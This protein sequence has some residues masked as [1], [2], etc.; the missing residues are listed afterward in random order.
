MKRLA[1]ILLALLAFPLH[2]QESQKFGEKIDVNVV[3]LDAIV[4]DH[5]G[6]QILGLGPDDFDVRENGTPQKIDSV[7]YFTN[8]TLLTSPEEKAAFKVERVREDRYFVFFFDKPQDAA[9]FDDVMRARTAAKKFAGQLRP[10]DH[11][12]VAGHDVRLK[13]YGDFSNDPKQLAR[14]IDDAGSFGVGLSS[15]AGPILSTVDKQRMMSG[16]GT[17]YEALEVLGD[18][19]RGVKGRKNLILFSPGILEPGQ[20]VRGGV[21]VAQSR[22]Y[23]PMIDALN[24]AN[25]SVYAM[26]LL[27]D[28]PDAPVYHQTLQQMAQD[29]NGDYYRHPVNF[30]PLIK[31]VEQQTNGYYLI[32]YTSHHPKGEHGFQKVDVDVKSKDLRVQA[33][34]GYLFGG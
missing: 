6:N 4:T 5:R 23:R 10:G 31:R 14:A 18:A 1:P 33:R 27:E 30:E 16:S 9:A 13:I 34:S 15:G 22:Y 3:L 25:V 26:N 29:T 2:A 11:V 28:V 8:R 12:A 24:A 21:I 32:T 19:L 17:V 20:D 7:E